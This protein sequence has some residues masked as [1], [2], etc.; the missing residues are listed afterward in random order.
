MRS[1]APT[2]G[3]FKSNR[4]RQKGEC[5]G[6]GAWGHS[7][8]CQGLGDPACSP[9]RRAWEALTHPQFPFFRR[10]WRGKAEHKEGLWSEL[11]SST[12]VYTGSKGGW[13]PQTRPLV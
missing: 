2:S 11:E 8:F 5:P 7:P 1:Y 10:G 3:R 12:R 6:M 4:V 13:S 9:D